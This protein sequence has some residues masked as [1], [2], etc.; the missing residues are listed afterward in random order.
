M[1]AIAG[2]ADRLAAEFG[3][4]FPTALEALQDAGFR[5]AWDRAH[6]GARAGMLTAWRNASR[7]VAEGKHCDVCDGPAKSIRFASSERE[8]DYRRA[9]ITVPAGAT[10]LIAFALVCAAC[11]QLSARRLAVRFLR[12]AG[13][14]TAPGGRPGGIRP[15]VLG[16]RIG[17]GTAL[18]ARRILEACER[19]QTM[20]WVDEA[21]YEGL[22]RDTR[23]MAL[24]GACA[25]G[26]DVQSVN[27]A[28]VL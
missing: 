20:L 17:E 8:A 16:A 14:M 7:A 24:C 19:C 10:G 13:G 5:S 18:P 23:P 2:Q 15:V 22:A 25:G 1:P 21:R 4:G 12:R 6:E 26:S 9:G 3:A 11:S 28:L 27:A